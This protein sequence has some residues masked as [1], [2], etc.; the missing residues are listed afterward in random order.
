M[1][2]EKTGLVDAVADT[3]EECID[4]I[5]K[6]LKYLPQNATE[7]APM[8]DIPDGSGME[9]PIFWIFYLKDPAVFMI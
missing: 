6:Y 7:P 4:I 9:W 2:Y 5:K 3:E 1:H 8:Q